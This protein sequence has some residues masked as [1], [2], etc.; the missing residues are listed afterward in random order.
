[1]NK[2]NVRLLLACAVLL[3]LLATVTATTYYLF[4]TSTI[5]ITIKEPLSFTYPSTLEL[6]VG[7]NKTFMLNVTN[8]VNA[9]FNVWFNFTLND[10]AYQTNYVTFSNTI[11]TVLASAVAQPCEAWIWVNGTAPANKTLTLTVDAYRY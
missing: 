8:A 10:S 3:V 6:F 9:S 1:M 11:Y 2:K 5:P 7:E 4:Q